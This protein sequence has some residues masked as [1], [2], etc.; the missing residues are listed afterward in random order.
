ML[1]VIEVIAV[2]FPLMLANGDVLIVNGPVDPGGVVPDE[3]TVTFIVTVAVLYKVVSVGVYVAIIDV[4][5]GVDT[6]VA[7]ELSNGFK[8]TDV[9]LETA[10]VNTPPVGPLVMVGGTKVQLRSGLTDELDHANTGVIFAPA[11]KTVI[12]TEFGD[13]GLKPAALCART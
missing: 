4:T 5:P 9:P 6:A 3:A 13:A 10:Y 1:K 11:A 12:S 2:K 8:V 7:N